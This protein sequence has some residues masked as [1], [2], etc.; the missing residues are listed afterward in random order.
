MN[1]YD[2]YKPYEEEYGETKDETE[3][4]FTED[5]TNFY[6]DGE[7]KKPKLIIIVIGIIILL[8]ILLIILFSCSK[9]SNAN[10]S[11]Y[12]ESV[13]IPNA[14]ISPSFDKKTLEYEVTSDKD[15]VIIR[16]NTESKKATVSGCNR[17]VFISEVCKKHT[18]KVM[19]KDSETKEYVFNLCKK[20]NEAPIIKEVAITPSNYT[21]SSVKITVKAESNTKLHSEAYSFDD[22]VTW[23]S[24]NEF[25]VEENKILKI[26]VRNEDGNETSTTKEITNIDKVIPKVI[27]D[28]SIKS[29]VTTTSNVELTAEVA[30]TNVVS[31]YKYQWYKDDKL[32]KN[33]TKS[34]Y[35]ATTSGSYKV[36]VTTG[37][38]NKATSNI[39]KVV[40]KVSPSTG[41]GKYILSITSVTGNPASWTSKNVTLTVKAT[42]SNGLHDNAY[43][44]DGGKTFQKSNSK[45]F[46]SNQEVSIVIRDKKSNKTSYKV[47]ITKI[48]TTKPVINIA[49]DRYTNSTITAATTP[50]NTPSGYKYQWYKDNTIIK[51][52]TNK[53][54]TPT[55]AGTYKVVIKTG[56]GL[57]TEYSNIKISNKP[58]ATISLTSSVTS[59]KWTK[60]DVTLKAAVTN[61][62]AEKYEW[63]KGSKLYKD[64]TT[65]TCVL[66]TTQSETYK[67]RAVTSVG[68]TSFSTA[69]TVKIDK[70]A[71][72]AP[73]IVLNP[74][75][76]TSSN[77][78]AKINN[79]TDANSGVK[80]V[81]Y[82][83]D[84]KTW[85]IY[86]GAT[87]TILKTTG[88]KTI[89]ARTVDNVG[90]ISSIEKKVALCDKDTVLVDRYSFGTD[91]SGSWFKLVFAPKYSGLSGITKDKYEYAY[92]NPTKTTDT[93]NNQASKVTE[94]CGT[95]PPKNA[96]IRTT[97]SGKTIA[98]YQ[99][100]NQQ[101]CCFAVRPYRA[102]EISQLNR[103]TVQWKFAYSTGYVNADSY[104]GS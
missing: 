59:G 13:S 81:Q 42:A 103:W 17:Q 63:Y 47:K 33:A 98:L 57:Q 45:Q 43:S 74:K 87:A 29:G 100:Y 26:K 6:N 77:V 61:G 40:K 54:Y 99:K 37:S 78:T 1:Q 38:G 79:G 14:T 3:N 32:I 76:E 62:K 101:Y 89:Y 66:K 5:K 25:K 35:L 95:A 50:A 8:I 36:V 22:G 82:S 39:Y 91:E 34:T 44:F 46:S 53:A 27:V 4:E 67:V 90:N 30:P 94:K 83:Y 58:Q 24:S 73:T 92:W 96:K 41:N 10:I 71:P 70:T 51:G 49:G 84:K 31:G 104:N 20:N 11:T 69:V 102:T 60:S 80:E 72:T 9:R 28:G 21:N 86:K 48:D 55:V 85:K 2:D 75:T 68:N 15:S 12:L 97:T 18:V 93:T 7:D 23:Q 52:A 19:A 64:C 16:C 65:A 88:A 56:A